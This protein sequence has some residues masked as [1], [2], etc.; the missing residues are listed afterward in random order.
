[1]SNSDFTDFG[2][3]KVSKDDKTRKVGE[4]FSSVASQYDIMNDVMSLGIHRFW[5]RY[6]IHTAAIKKGDKVLDLA[7][8]TGDLSF[9]L[10]KR[11]GDN[12]QVTLADINGDMLREGRDRFINKGISNGINYAQVNAES[13][14][15]NS[16]SFDFISIA[17]GLRNVTDKLTALKS[18]HRCLKYGSQLMILEFSKLSLPVFQKIYDE[19]SFKFIPKFGKL[20]ANDEA[21]YQYLV[22]SIRMHPDQETLKGLLQ[23][24]GFERVSYKNLSAGIV[25]IHTAYKI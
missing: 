25:A 20:I 4:V 9:K 22:E 23:Q 10:L 15:F 18:M 2:F 16:N 6:A 14:P 12:G 11:V 3:E 8:G 19:Y 7:G 17:F 21:S 5:K 1:M 13:L 24:A